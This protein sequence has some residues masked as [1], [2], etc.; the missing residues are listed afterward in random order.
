[1]QNSDKNPPVKPR[2]GSRPADKM[3]EKW[4]ANFSKP[5]KSCFN[6]KSEI[7]FNAY[8]EKSRRLK[9]GE[10]SG[11][12]SLFIGLKKNKCMAWLETLCRVYVDQV[13]DT[14]IRIENSGNFCAAGLLFRVDGRGSYY[15]AL[16][17]S[18]GYF[19]LYAIN[20]GMPEP[21]TGW[22]EI[23]DPD[24][25]V[26]NIKIIARGD[27]MIFIVNKKWTAE[28]HDHSIPGGHL[29]F[30][31]VSYDDDPET[32]SV[33]ILSSLT[34]DGYC[35]RAWL[36]Y[37]SVDSRSRIVETE[38]KKWCGPAV[39]IN[40]EN[41]MH[42]AES[43]ANLNRP[44]AA[45]N[46]M[47]TVWK[48]RE[49]AARSVTATYTEMRSK[50][51][52]FFAASMAQR[53]GRHEI[54]EDYIDACIASDSGFP[55]EKILTEKIKIMDSLNKNTELAELLPGYIE[56]AEKN[57]LLPAALLPTLNG[58]LGYVYWNLQ[59]YKASAEVWDRAFSLDGSN[60]LYAANAANAWEQLGKIKEAFNRR[61]ESGKI[62]LKQKN[63][64]ELGALIPKLL[65][66]GGVPGRK[67][68]EVQEL[69]EKWACAAGAFS[70][71][72]NSY[73][74][75][76][77]NKTKPKPVKPAAKNMAAPAKS[78]TIKKTVTAKPAEKKRGAPEKSGTAK[79]K[80]SVKTAVKKQEKPSAVKPVK[81]AAAGKTGRQGK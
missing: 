32:D 28:A 58:L 77:A 69:L 2:R 59:N 27:H 16:V 55:D 34:E 33:E 68:R 60:G 79:K 39:E 45:L 12:G 41:R 35:C 61:L 31:L 72:A 9:K 57:K 19:C 47:L 22:I 40:A 18:K 62:F 24:G 50:A 42:L 44:E 36:E 54:A 51:E 46:Q 66:A 20:G 53:L 29:G 13:I 52:L 7:P 17:S 25:P 23:P 76:A 26:T 6:I 67:N 78:G 4:T 65:A 81:K 21:L 63:Y 71:A 49:E 73:G 1:M 56:Q 37:L 15:L 80:A 10:I 8:L 5:E 75:D 14:R 70:F 30:A 11:K 43:F 74:K 48:Q 64:T 3:K 38:Y